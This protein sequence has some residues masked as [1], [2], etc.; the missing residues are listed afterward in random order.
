MILTVITPSVF[1]CPPAG[2]E[3]DEEGVAAAKV[4]L[5]GALREFGQEAEGMTV[6]QEALDYYEKHPA[7]GKGL[8][9]AHQWLCLLYTS[10]S[11][12]D[13]TRSRMPSSA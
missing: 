8:L 5:A 13:R 10:P 7:D 2:A 1:D 3:G 11:P 12:R 6:T 4:Q 9:R